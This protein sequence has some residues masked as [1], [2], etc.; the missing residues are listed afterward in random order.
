M[1][2]A[3]AELRAHIGINAVLVDIP[4]A[5]GEV[6]GDRDGHPR[7]IDQAADRLDEAL[8]EGGLADEDRAVVVLQGA[9]ENFAGAG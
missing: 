4:A 6:L 8:A 5:G 2:L 7:S 1:D 3:G 9:G